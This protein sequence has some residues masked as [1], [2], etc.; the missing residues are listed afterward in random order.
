MMRKPIHYVAAAML[1]LC[2]QVLSGCVT[3]IGVSKISPREAYQDAYA[4]AMSA[5]VASE[6]TKD[7]LHR[8][9]LLHKFKDDPAAVITFLHVKALNDK[10]R[11]IFYA[12][13]E[14][15]YLYAG[16]LENSALEEDQRLAPDYF[17]LSALYAYYYF[18][19]DRS[20]PKPSLFDHRV[21]SALDLY[22]YGLWQGLTTGNGGAFVLEER[23]RKLPLGKIAISMDTTHIPWKIEEFDQFE[24]ADKYRVRGI[25]VRNRKQGVGLPLIAIKQE[26]DNAL[27]LALPITAFMRVKGGFTSLDAGTATASLELYSTKDSSNLLVND[28]HYP[29][30]SDSTISLAYKLEG[31]EI[32]G[33]AI[34]SFLGKEFR[35]LP[36]GLYLSDPYQPGRIPVVFVHGTA[37]SPI[38]WTEMFNTLK[39]DPLISQKYQFWFFVYT[40]S[41]PIIS[42]AAD[43]RTALNK[44]IAS[45]DPRGKDPALRQMVVVGHSQ[46]GLLAKLAAVDTVENLVRA[47]TGKNLESLKMPDKS[48]AEVRNLLV[49]QPLPFVK[50]VVFLSTPHRGSFRSKWWNRSLVAALVTLPSTLVQST[51][52][53]YDYLN[54][55]T[56]KL[57]GGKKS[58][59]TS[60]DGQSPD[61][62][63][64]KALA[65]LPLAPG[66]KG[67]SIISVDSDGDPKLGNDGVV[68]YT[69][70]HLDGMDSELIVNSGHSSQLNPIAIDEVRRILLEGLNDS[71]RNNREKK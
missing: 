33:S 70:A 3:P 13:A 17:L 30:E 18:S 55:D 65:E 47:L 2:V 50:E 25:S 15:S 71:S 54:D 23:V 35:K 67:H 62:P 21:R 57:V 4:N 20:D 6:Q 64:L 10:R 45:L 7:V 27:S 12:L 46:G 29:L 28:I 61:N 32:W 11:D 58:V 31:A 48:K 5:G 9:D 52:D 53:Y 56:R 60:A 42:S 34:S 59:F 37:S 66:I 16:Q 51:V 22:R 26:S 14:T 24:P 69:S 44:K 19:E 68:E 63:L 36:N 43:L 39:S 41:K 8:F 1:L 40:S 38:W 49:L